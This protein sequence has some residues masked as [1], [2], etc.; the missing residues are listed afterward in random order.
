MGGIDFPARE[1]CFPIGETQFPNFPPISPKIPRIPPISQ[2]FL[3]IPRFRVQFSI[4][5]HKCTLYLS[6]K[7]IL[8]ILHVSLK[9][10]IPHYARQ[11]IINLVNSGGIQGNSGE[12]WG[13]QMKRLS[14]FSLVFPG[15]KYISLL[16]KSNSPDF[17][18]GYRE[19]GWKILWKKMKV[20]MISVDSSLSSPLQY[21]ITLL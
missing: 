12:F 1:L 6:I 17:S 5:L 3:L 7:P 16:G 21:R 8:C 14:F 9:M 18:C 15:V 13:N 11:R 4:Q 10:R 19:N 2:W 20:S